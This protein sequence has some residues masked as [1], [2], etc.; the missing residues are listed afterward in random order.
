VIKMF[1]VEFSGYFEKKLAK[2]VDS[3]A[4]IVY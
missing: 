2:R 3:P 4:S 1:G